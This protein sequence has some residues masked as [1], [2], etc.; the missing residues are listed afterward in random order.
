MRMINQLPLVIRGGGPQASV[1]ARPVDF[2]SYS[3]VLP[4]AP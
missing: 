1:I 4:V 3:D 2:R